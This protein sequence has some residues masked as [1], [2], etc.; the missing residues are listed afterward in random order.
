MYS[1]H[2]VHW[3]LLSIRA[4]QLQVSWI[5]EYIFL[6]IHKT[7]WGLECPTYETTI[8]KFG[9]HTAYDGQGSIGKFEGPHDLFGHCNLLSWACDLGLEI[10]S[11]PCHLWLRSFDPNHQNTCSISSAQCM[12]TRVSKCDMW[13]CGKVGVNC[14][15]NSVIINL[16]CGII[17]L[18]FP[19]HLLWPIYCSYSS[20]FGRVI[21]SWRLCG[22]CTVWLTQV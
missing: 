22:H 6:W 5:H 16:V 8:C 20:P 2:S 7:V 3:Q 10:I 4:P 12:G 21:A 13:T 11:G 9:V 19:G 1:P 15:W 18:K 17:T 14:H